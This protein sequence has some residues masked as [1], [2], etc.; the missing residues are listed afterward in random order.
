MISS[1]TPRLRAMDDRSFNKPARAEGEH[2]EACESQQSRHGEPIR[3]AGLCRLRRNPFFAGLPDEEAKLEHENN[4][5]HHPLGSGDQAVP[6]Q[7]QRESGDRDHD[8]HVQADQLAVNDEGGEDSG[9]TE[10]E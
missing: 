5:Q 8:R 6:P 2:P 7:Q 3:P 9:Q 10:D 4:H 1:L